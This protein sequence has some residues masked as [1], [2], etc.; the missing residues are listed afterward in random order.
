MGMTIQD[1]VTYW[2]QV[3]G[4][5]RWNDRTVW[6]WFTHQY[7]KQILS[8]YFQNIQLGQKVLDIGCGSGQFVPE[9]S[10]NG[11]L[12]GIDISPEAIKTCR[13]RFPDKTFSECSATNLS[14]FPSRYFDWV[15]TVVTLCCI[16]RK[17][18]LVKAISEITRVLCPCGHVVFLEHLDSQNKS[19][20]I[21]T[22]GPERFM[23]MI[24]SN[25]PLILKSNRH[26]DVP[27]LRNILEKGYAK[28]PFRI[29]RELWTAAMI[30]VIWPSY[31]LFP[32]G[33]SSYSLIE[34]EKKL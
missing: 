2:D 23:T 34:A 11:E 22:L 26:L 5:H 20:L 25:F 17:D 8:P 12:T 30:P 32:S 13:K 6:T 1:H 18:E 27:V 28:L 7:H 4:E 19:S 31:K 15:F 33:N 3:Y 10:L 14:E 9:M 16:T 24:E 29:L 21:I